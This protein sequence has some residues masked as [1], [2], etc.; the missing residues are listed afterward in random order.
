MHREWHPTWLP[1]ASRS[2]GEIWRNGHRNAASCR[3]PS[4]A[5]D[6]PHAEQRRLHRFVDSARSAR[7][8][9]AREEGLAHDGPSC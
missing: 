3:E 4:S 9:R 1:A 6:H 7:R 5:S 2:C 8:R